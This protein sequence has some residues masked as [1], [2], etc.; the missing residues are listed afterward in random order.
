MKANKLGRALLIILL[1]G[2]A[3][4]L[5]AGTAV[6]EHWSCSQCD[7]DPG[8]T[9]DL[10]LGPAYVA[11]DAYQFGDYSGLDEKGA[12]L[13]GDLRGEYV[14]DRAGYF[15]LD[16]FSRSS[17]SFGLFAEGGRQGS[18]EIRGA[19][20]SIPRR[21]YDAALT[22]FAGSNTLSLPDSWV[23]APVTSEMSNLA[24][25]LEPVPIKRDLDVLKLGVSIHP[26]SRWK[27]DADYRR[28]T[29]KGHSLSSGSFLFSA[30]EFASPV[31]YSTDDLELALSF[32]GDRWQT[33]LRYLGSFF[34]NDHDRVSWDNPFTGLPGADVAG[35][36]LAPDNELH[37]LTL[38]G[39]WRLPKRTVLSGQL[40]VGTLSQDQD[41]EPY[42]LNPTI[43]TAPLPQASADAEAD[44]LNLNLRAVT[45]PWRRVTLEGEVRFNQFDNRTS[46]R[47]YD[48]VITDAVAAAL[49]AR[50][51]AYDYER[52][53]LK[54]R[55][56]FRPGRRLKLHAGFDSRRFERTAQDR[57]ETNTDKFWFRLH[58]RLGD[59]A[60]LDFDLFTEQREGSSY[61][62]LA[63]PAAEQNPLLRKYNLSDRERYGIRFRGSVFP[64]QRW[65][66]G[67]EF[68]YGEDDYSGD[69]GLTSSSYARA[70]LDLSWM[71]GVQGSLYGNVHTETVDAEQANSQRFAAPDW[72]AT[73]TDRF[74]DA[75][76]GF[77]HPAL[78]GPLG[79][80]LAYSWSR[81]RGETE[82]NTSGLENAFPD[83]ISRRHRFDLG[84]TYPLGDAWTLGV[85][86]LYEKVRSNDWALDGLAPDTVPN[87]LSL[88]ADPFNY[89]VNVIYLSF[90][91]LRTQE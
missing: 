9:L 47:D 3:R 6:P 5:A 52:T 85:N 70:G 73:S 2:G 50:N 60:D 82:N 61:E 19:Y 53:E 62:V 28:Q 13:F 7:P 16:G 14:D 22:P 29:R 31:D 34:G 84:L 23:R 56:E 1:C 26:G 59:N 64:A 78:I 88:G 75:S 10:T 12:Y 4:D 8:W 91:Y 55:A 35:Q 20:Q 30:A 32:S 58:H 39:A 81:G 40:A 80:S 54:L 74:D 25:G 41:L 67:W 72:M 38:A 24:D 77:D 89:E 11:D 51:P 86:Y 18:Y 37:Q 63:R 57:R 90:R 87:L 15:H 27:L 21:F 76:V 44:T 68:E 48:Y 43:V 66:L 79:V 17:D 65:D 42:T 36:A 46:A 71:I 83:L 45:S 69:I 49:P 33:S